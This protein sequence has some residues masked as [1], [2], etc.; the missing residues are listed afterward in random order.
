MASVL[1]K[2]RISEYEKAI[3]AEGVN[4]RLIRLHLDACR[5]CYETEKDYKLA[6]RVSEETKKYV[7][8]YIKQTTKGTF[9][10]LERYAQESDKRFESV[11]WMYELWKMEAVHKFESFCFY[12]EHKRPYEKRFYVPRR[13][14]LSVVANDFQRLEDDELDTY[15][16]SMPS[17]TGKSTMGVFFMAWH[18]L[19]K[20]MSHNAMGGHSGILAKRFFRGLSNLIETEEYTFPE[21]FFYAHP[22]LKRVV[23]S[24]SSDPSEYTINL[25]KPDEFSTYTCRGID[26]TWTGAVDVSEDGYLY[27]DD[28]VRDREHS[29]SAIRME[30]TYQEY[31]NKMLDRMNDGAKKILIGTLWGVG[32]PLE[33]ERLLD[34]DNPRR[35]FRKIPALDPETD[36][37]NFQYEYKGFSTKYYR[38][39]RD[40][41]DRAEWMAKFQQQ[42]FVREGLLFPQEELRYF[43]GTIPDDDRRVVAACDPAYG[44]GDSVSMP[45]CVDYGEGKEKFI[46]DWVH[47]NRTPQYTVI[48]VV[49][50]IEEHYITELKIEQNT[51]GGLFAEDVQEEMDKRGIHFCKIVTKYAPV[52]ISKEDKIGGYSDYIKRWFRFLPIKRMSE[53]DELE[54]VYQRS[55][56]YGRAMDELVLYSGEGKNLHDDA[57]DALTQVA[58]MFDERRVRKA[59]IMGSPI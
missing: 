33:R 29:L 21:L 42:P 47:D 10:D 57:P 52:K 31:Q 22:R 39:M 49:N 41:L 44:R 14:T 5:T 55:H 18:G 23:E 32:D 1:L 19:R 45:V 37:S 46:I 13:K 6:L 9:W 17:R 8:K 38:E 27:I 51:G 11:E 24:K 56:Q 35:L 7:N 12:M 30:N 40:R 28:M 54:S 50:K 58:M 25:G 34:P 16:L 15:G 26:G 2:K 59:V 43:N 53:S 48:E 4:D 3:E 20:P 36:E